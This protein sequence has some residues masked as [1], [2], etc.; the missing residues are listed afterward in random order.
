MTLLYQKHDGLQTHPTL[1]ID[2]VNSERDGPG[3]VGGCR[4]LLQTAKGGQDP[5]AVPVGGGLYPLPLIG[6]KGGRL[7]V[8]EDGTPLAL[9]VALA[10][11]SVKKQG[12][13][14]VKY[15]VLYFAFCFCFSTGAVF[16]SLWKKKLIICYS[17][18]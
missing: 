14:K 7:G 9:P 2:G 5:E 11:R 3:G 8:G 6:A 10:A 12:E 15:F 1:D 13:K 16:L 17:M 4:R 18:L